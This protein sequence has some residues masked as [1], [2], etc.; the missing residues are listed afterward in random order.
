LLYTKSFKLLKERSLGR[1]FVGS[2]VPNNNPRIGI[3][4]DIEKRENK[5]ESRFSNE[6]K[7]TKKIY[8]FEKLKIRRVDFIY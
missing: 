6:F 7:T 5:A 2:I 1:S 3:I 8:G 4:S